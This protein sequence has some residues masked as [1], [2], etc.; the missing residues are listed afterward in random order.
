MSLEKIIT[1]REFLL[2]KIEISSFFYEQGCKKWREKE[3]KACQFQARVNEKTHVKNN[4]FLNI[5]A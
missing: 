5:S 2:N 3:R 4:R 1:L